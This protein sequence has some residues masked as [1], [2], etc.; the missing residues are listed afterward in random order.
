MTTPV[1]RAMRE[2]LAG[3]T[4]IGI[5]R[6]GHDELLDG[7]P[8]L[9]ELIPLNI[10]GLTGPWRARRALRGC[11]AEAVLLLPNSFRSALAAR[12]SGA[13][14]R[15]GYRRDGRGPLLT[16]PLEVER[17]GLP[18]PTVDYYLAL[19]RFALGVDSIR[20]KPELSVTD[21][22]EAAA[23]NLLADVEGPF[24]LLNP[25]ASKKE[26]RWP[27]ERFAAAA[28]ALAGSR[29]LAVVAGGAP[30]EADLI[31]ELAGIA[32]TRIVNLADR[33]LGL[34]SLKAVIRRATVLITNDTGPRHIAAALGTPT[35][36]LFG[37]TDHRWTTLPEARERILLAE[38]FLPEEL[39]ADRMP[40]ICSIDR[41][42]TADV[43]AAVESLLD[44]PPSAGP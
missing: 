24:L 6:P 5:V 11:E 16:H 40:K 20:P 12:L 44:D 2:E 8:W 34:G 9:D 22:Q 30:S 43:I 39:V 21:W 27:I 31:R 23:D 1:L 26:K 3:A 28:D 37:P 19:G 36:C 42:R 29:S 41:I 10:K 14:V 38:P 17:T 33:G 25:G 4:L 13:P 18:T 7:S 35:V 15:I 32:H